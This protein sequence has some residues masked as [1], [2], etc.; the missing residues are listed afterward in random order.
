[1]LDHDGV[2]VAR[3]SALRLRVGESRDALENP[4]RPDESP[5]RPPIRHVGSRLELSGL[6]VPG[7]IRALDLDQV[8]GGIGRGAPAISWYRLRVP[9][10]EGDDTSP[11]ACGAVFEG[12]T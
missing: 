6:P 10:I 1:A 11:V 9:L 12:F 7:F 3:A 5:P 2:E 4:F 8:V